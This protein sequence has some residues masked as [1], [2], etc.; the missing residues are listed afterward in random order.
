MTA[1]L[2]V[3]IGL[4]ALVLGKHLEDR[5]VHVEVARRSRQR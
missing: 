3:G 5:R 1:L 4:A 2:L